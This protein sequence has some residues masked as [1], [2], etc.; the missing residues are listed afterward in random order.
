MHNEKVDRYYPK[1]GS[2]DGWVVEGDFYA[3]IEGND[4]GWNV[5]HLQQYDYTINDSKY[6][7]SEQ[8][9]SINPDVLKNNTN[10][11]QAGIEQ[12]GTKIRDVNKAMKMA[13]SAIP[14]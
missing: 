8:G 11:A 5:A 6:Y 14:S 9:K 7:M 3:H 4:K 13:M 1:G 12:S 2:R 10:L